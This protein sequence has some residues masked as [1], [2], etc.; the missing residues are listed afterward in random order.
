[1]VL[2]YIV[3]K[4]ILLIYRVYYFILFYFIILYEAQQLQRIQLKI[5]LVEIN[6][7]NYIEKI[8]K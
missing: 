3:W 5:Q 2:Y 6:I 8:L 7:N 1:M 4:N